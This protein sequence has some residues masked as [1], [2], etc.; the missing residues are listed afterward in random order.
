MMEVHGG[1]VQVSLGWIVP[2]MVWKIVTL[3]GTNR[4]ETLRR[5][6]RMTW[7]IAMKTMCVCV[8]VV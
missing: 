4:E 7:I 1:N 2:R 5:Q 6:P 3:R 8:Y